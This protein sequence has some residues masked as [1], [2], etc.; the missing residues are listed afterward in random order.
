MEGREKR[1]ADLPFSPHSNLGAARGKSPLTHPQPHTLATQVPAVACKPGGAEA[2][3]ARSPGGGRGAAV[4]A[5]CEPGAARLGDT[6]LAGGSCAPRAWQRTQPSPHCLRVGL[7][8]G[9]QLQ[10]FMERGAKL[11]RRLGRVSPKL[12]ASPCFPGDSARQGKEL[13]ILEVF[14]KHDLRKVI[15]RKPGPSRPPA[16][17]LGSW[18]PRTVRSG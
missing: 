1:L 14:S 4:G 6:L 8:W 18:S 10:F 15:F 2:E 11:P 17:I 12:R 9:A 7:L 5:G 3:A 13:G 16:W